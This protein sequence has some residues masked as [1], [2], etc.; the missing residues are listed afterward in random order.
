MAVAVTG[1]TGELG[2]RVARRLAQRGQDQLLVGRDLARAPEFRGAE[3]RRIVGYGDARSV[4]AAVEGAHTL[5]LVP[6]S[7]A[8]DRVEQHITAV[9]AARD[10]GVERVVYL[11]FVNAAPHSTFTFARDHW[12][13]EEHIR[14]T[15]LPFVFAR[16]SMYMDFIPGF[17]GED[18]VIRGPA[19][20]GRVGA[21]LRDD[22]ADACAALLATDGHEGRTYDLTGPRSISLAEVAEELSRATG[23]EVRYEHETVEQAWAS[24]AG[25]GAPEWEVE[26]WITSYTA[27]AAGELDVVSD[28]VERLA[29]HPP[30]DLRD[31]LP[32]TP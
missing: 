29:G 13:T 26:G 18:G 3:Q 11:S 24:R 17:A 28:A 5:F 25:S 30:T 4:R 22:V 32:S 21:V 31:W 1:A 8:E 14:S 9:D 12:A 15:G 27:I 6:A 20:D 23:R 10:A 2:S 19:G 7:E 16:M